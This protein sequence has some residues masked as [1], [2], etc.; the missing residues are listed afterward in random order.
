[1]QVEVPIPIAPPSLF[2]SRSVFTPVHPS[3]Y[4][5]IDASLPTVT[6]VPKSPSP[7]VAIPPIASSPFAPSP[8]KPAAVFRPPRVKRQWSQP[9]KDI[10]VQKAREIGLT[11]ATRYLQNNYPAVF[12]DLSPSTL[13]YWMHKA[14]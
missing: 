4:E 3:M 14:A 1:M 5:V 8:M 13:Q 7:S 6:V 11:R 2:Y 12:R 10:A 9:L